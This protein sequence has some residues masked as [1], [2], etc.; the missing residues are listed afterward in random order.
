MQDEDL[1][2]ELFSEI[3]QLVRLSIKGIATGMRTTG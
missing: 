3:Q 1:S 2:D